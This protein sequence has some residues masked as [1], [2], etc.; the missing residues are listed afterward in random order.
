MLQTNTMEVLSIINSPHTT[1]VHLFGKNKGICVLAS[2]ND[3]VNKS[4]II[5]FMYLKKD[6]GLFSQKI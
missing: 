1:A 3:Q 6:L 4:D 2:P 5:R